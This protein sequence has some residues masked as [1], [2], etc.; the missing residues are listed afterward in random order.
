M[1]D[2]S[3]ADIQPPHLRPA[4]NRRAATGWVKKV[5]RWTTITGAL[6]CCL[7]GSAFAAHQLVPSKNGAS[8]HAFNASR[9]YERTPFDELDAQQICQFQTQEQHGD[10]LVLSYL[11]THS[12][13]Y[14]DLSYAYKVFIFAHIGTSAEYEEATIHCFI[15]PDKHLIKHYKTIFPER[16]SLMTR[17]LSFFTGHK[18]KGL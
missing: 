18:S 2:S 7:L 11:D 1:L 6:A 17:A 13:R 5:L 9:D 3:S 16:E 4:A 10:K 14:D 15:D 8:V 12:T